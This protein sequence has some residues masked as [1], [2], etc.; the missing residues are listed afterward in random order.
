MMTWNIERVGHNNFCSAIEELDRAAKW[1]LLMIQ[2]VSM[3]NPD[4]SEG[5]KREDHDVVLYRY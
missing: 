4:V 5:I 1:E 3:D 2:E